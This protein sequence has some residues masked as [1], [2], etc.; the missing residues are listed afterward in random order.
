MQGV[1]PRQAAMVA[2]AVPLEKQ[3]VTLKIQE[4]QPISVLGTP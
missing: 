3:Q 1:Y 2:V 4:R